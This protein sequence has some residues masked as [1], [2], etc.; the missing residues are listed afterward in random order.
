MKMYYLSATGSNQKSFHEKAMV[1]IEDGKE[2][3]FSYNTPVCYIENGRF[4]RT[5]KGWSATTAKHINAFRVQN[6]LP[7]ISKKEWMDLPC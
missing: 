5:W 7:K 2:I 6:N 4:V 1:R 3:L